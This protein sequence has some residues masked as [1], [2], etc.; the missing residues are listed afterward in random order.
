MYIVRRVATYENHVAAAER[1]IMNANA[2]S[3]VS[4][5]DAAQ[6]QV[7]AT[8]ALVEAVLAVATAIRDLPDTPESRR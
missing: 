2:L 4:S 5:D 6:M 1:G 7:V 8:L 3:N